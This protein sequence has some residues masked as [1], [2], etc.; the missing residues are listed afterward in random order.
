MTTD[1]KAEKRGTAMSKYDALWEYVGRNEGESFKLSFEQ[2]G[3]IA[4]AAI[5]HSFLRYKKDLEQYGWQVGKISMKEQ[6]IT[7]LRII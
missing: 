7:F 1:F 5:D 6:T 2:A 4:Q 3:R